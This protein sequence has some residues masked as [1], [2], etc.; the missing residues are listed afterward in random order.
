MKTLTE[1]TATML[2]LFCLATPVHAQNSDSVIPDV[3]YGHKAGMALTM[4]IFMPP[5]EPNGV[6][7]LNMVSAPQPRRPGRSRGQQRSTTAG[8]GGRRA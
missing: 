8:G 1:A 3:V 4:D 5:G 7:I 2:T 6:G